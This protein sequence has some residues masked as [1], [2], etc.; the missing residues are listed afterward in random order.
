M[1]FGSR[2][3][4]KHVHQAVE[5]GERGEDREGG[6]R[7]NY[8]V[9]IMM[10]TLSLILPLD[11][12]VSCFIHWL[13]VSELIIFARND[14]HDVCPKHSLAQRLSLPPSDENECAD[15]SRHKCRP[16][17]VAICK[18]KKNGYDCLC[19]SKIQS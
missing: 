15:S 8:N 17:G 3:R 6:S 10:T 14:S 16:I 1:L 7:K 19:P 18:D 13:H 5:G 11:L 12:M 4:L 9:I 2:I